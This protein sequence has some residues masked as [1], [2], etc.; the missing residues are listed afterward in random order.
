MF[1][2]ITVEGIKNR[3]LSRITTDLQTREGSFTNDVISAVSA[4]IAEVYHS[5]DA[6]LPAFYVGENRGAYIDMQANAAGVVRKAGTAASCA[7]HFTG[8]DGATIPAGAPFYTAA[9]LTFYLQEAIAIVDGA[10]SGTLLAAQ[11]GEVYNIGV[12]EI[13]ST[14][15]NYSGITSY[16]NEAAQGGTDPESDKAL[17]ARY[18]DQRQRPATSGNP[19]NYQQWATS[20][21]GIGAA[22]VISK[23]NGAGTVKVVLAGPSMGVPDESAVEDATQYIENQHPVGPAVTTVAAQPHELTVE[24]TVTIDSTTTVETVC[25]ALESAVQ[26]Y[27]QELTRTAFRSNVDLQFETLEE[28]SSTVLYNRIAFLLL[29]ISGVV[30]FAELTVNG[31]AENVTIP[32]DALPILTEVSVQ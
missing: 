4:E 20:V 17:L 18:Q 9:G 19:Y 14:L 8:T 31:S 7:I 11:V 10:A 13:V 27:L 28:K 6:F 12:G 5:M 30:D 24:A 1:E 21:D 3:V 15:R 32:A 16:E 23:W 2:N 29:S 22:R 26:A 25:S